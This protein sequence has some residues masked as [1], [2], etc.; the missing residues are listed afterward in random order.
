MMPEPRISR[1]RFLQSAA[2]MSLAAVGVGEYAWQVETWW[3]EIVRQELALPGLPDAFAGFTIAQISDLH[4]GRY[5]SPADFEPV[6]RAV[7]ELAADVIVITGDLVTHVSRGEP[8][9]IVESLSRLSAAEGVF[10]ILGN[11]DWSANGPL[12]AESLRLA[13]VT[14]LQ[15]SH[16]AWQRDGQT[17]VLAGVDDVCYGRQ[18]LPAALAGVPRN[19]KTVLLA[20]EPD[21]AD[22][23]ARDPRVV[24]QLSGHSH[25]GQICIPGVGGL[26]FPRLARKYT[27][28]LYSVGA[29]TLYTNR[30]LGTMGLPLRFCCRPEVTLFTLQPA[31][32][33]T[34]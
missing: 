19:G 2:G 15:N 34:A 23:A 26:F 16:V 24:L 7:Q 4:L 21:Y 1:R 20:H 27:S 28:G 3:F 30:G 22:L 5:A 8:D 14:V 12:V 25:G 33:V 29:L 11:H 18:D 32:S 17:L 10:A 6:L 13:G 31:R 9:M